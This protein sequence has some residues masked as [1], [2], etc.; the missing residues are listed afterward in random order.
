MKNPALV[1]LFPASSTNLYSLYSS[2]LRLATIRR[3]K[4]KTKI[5]VS[6]LLKTHKKGNATHHA[7]PI[8][9]ESEQ[10]VALLS[11]VKLDISRAIA[12]SLVHSYRLY[13]YML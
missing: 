1:K 4:E 11:L 3:R 12:K 10:R 2:D 5:M 9:H 13:F 7:S 6:A 8:M